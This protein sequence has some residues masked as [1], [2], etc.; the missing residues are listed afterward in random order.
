[1]TV[2]KIATLEAFLVPPRWL[3]VRI[4]TDQ[5]AIGWG[6]A[7]LEGHGEAVLGA[8]EAVRDRIVGMDASRIEDIWQ[9]LYR[10]GFYRGGPVLMSAISG[11]DQALW[12]IKGRMLGVPVSDLLGGRVRDRMRVYA[13]VGGDRPHDVAAAALERRQQGFDAV[14]MNGTEDMAWLDSPASVDAAAERLALVR[15]T[16]V[17]VGVDFHGRVHKP[18]A[19]QLVRALEP[20]RPLFVEEVLAN[21]QLEAIAQ[22]AGQTSVPLALG[23]RLYSRWQFK[24]FF[25][26]AAID[27]A[28]PDL[29]HAGGI[30]ECR[31]IAAMAET[32]DVAFAPHCPLGPLALASCFQVAAVTL[33][34]VIQEMSIGIHYNRP[35]ADLLTFVR[36]PEALRVTDGMVAVLEG[37]GLGVDIDEDAVRSA[38]IQPHRWRNPVWRGRD[39]SLREW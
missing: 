17:D 15:E 38:A 28:Q 22:I 25:E 5:G 27:I 7:S 36:N 1:M 13:W 2:H 32:Y 39:G 31:R 6:E 30:S 14:K 29:S 19:R 34:F 21:E 24:P 26:A 12:D 3:F 10:L 23:E 16:G 8:M 11:V 4:E 37:P 35:D 33:N 18:M 9:L 20:L